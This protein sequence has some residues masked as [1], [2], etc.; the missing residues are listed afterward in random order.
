MAIN[1]SNLNG[2]PALPEG[3]S[4]VAFLMLDGLRRPQPDNPHEVALCVLGLGG[5]GMPIPL[6]LRVA[7]REDEHAW[8]SLLAHL[9]ARGIGRE[10]LLVVCDDH[11]ALLKAVQA[12][13][14][15]VPMQVSVAHRLLAL[16]RK[17]DA[18]S[19]AACLAEAR[20]IF[21]APDLNT[22]VT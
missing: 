5:D 13:Y 9:R 15:E 2:K 14:P 20:E 10:A 8:R 11:P 12:V 3:H 6:A 18:P 17:V 1:A 7:Q 19:R 16:A 21:A 4:G 22:A